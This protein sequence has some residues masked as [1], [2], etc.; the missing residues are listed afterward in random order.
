VADES[1]Q[2]DV[3]LENGLLGFGKSYFR[4]EYFLRGEGVTAWTSC[5]TGMWCVCVNIY[6]LWCPKGGEEAIYTPVRST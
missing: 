4:M 5:G 2:V 6:E 1:G 3:R